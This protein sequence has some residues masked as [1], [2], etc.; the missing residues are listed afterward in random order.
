MSNNNKNILILYTF[1]YIQLIIKIEDIC[2]IL[3]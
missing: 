2:V 3:V 1:S